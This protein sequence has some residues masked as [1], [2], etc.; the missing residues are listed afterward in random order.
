[1]NYI[2]TVIINDETGNRNYFYTNNES[3]AIE[4]SKQLTA[5][6]L[7]SYIKKKELRKKNEV[8]IT[9][10]I[11]LKFTKENLNYGFKSNFNEGY[12]P[13]EYGYDFHVFKRNDEIHVCFKYRNNLTYVL[14][15]KKHIEKNLKHISFITFEGVNVS[16]LFEMTE[17]E[18]EKYIVLHS[19]IIRFDR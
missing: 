9:Y 7:Y 11:F 4:V 8:D 10:S 3:E 18:L 12:L 19:G 6:N 15:N 13:E 17:N 1:M 2:Y 5:L 14:N 16:T